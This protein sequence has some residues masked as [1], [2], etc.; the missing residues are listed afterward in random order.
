[1][2]VLFSAQGAR[3][4]ALKAATLFSLGFFIPVA[5]LCQGIERWY[6]ADRFHRLTCG[7]AP[8]RSGQLVHQVYVFVKLSGLSDFSAFLLSAPNCGTVDEAHPATAKPS[9]QG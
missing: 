9:T 8:D 5:L 4:A 1:M 6:K 7:D 3:L 2:S